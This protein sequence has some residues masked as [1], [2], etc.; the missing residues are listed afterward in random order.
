MEAVGAR[1]LAR[2]GMRRPEASVTNPP[3]AV[4]SAARRVM[5]G[6]LG[7]GV[8][9]RRCIG[10]SPLRLGGG[11]AGGRAAGGLAV[12]VVIGRCLPSSR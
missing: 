5:W 8:M 9:G 6:R 12:R 1:V 11:R 2:A 4:A 3:A 7:A 10:G